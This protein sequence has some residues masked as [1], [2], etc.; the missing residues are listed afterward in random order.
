MAGVQEAEA[1]TDRA[2]LRVLVIVGAVDDRQLGLLAEDER[3]RAE[4]DDPIATTHL[5]TYREG[6]H[7]VRRN[8]DNAY[9]T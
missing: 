1:I 8:L 9:L 6:R 4:L 5:V 3:V 2:L 7:R